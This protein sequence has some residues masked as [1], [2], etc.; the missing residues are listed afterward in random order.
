MKK[1]LQKIFVCSFLLCAAGA[2][3]FLLYRGT[4]IAVPCF[5]HVITGLYCPGCG[6]TRC[7]SHLLS[8]ELR[9]AFYCNMAV[10]LLSPVFLFV[11]VS[12][13][14]SY[15]R[16]GK[17]VMGRIQNLLLWICLIVLILFGILRNLPCFI[18]L[19]PGYGL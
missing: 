12:S 10:M 11:L 14:C 1:R 3:Y 6:M 8:L 7:I 4:G 17:I 2:V 5:F 16:S 9:E 15:L 13:L 18:F 19:Q